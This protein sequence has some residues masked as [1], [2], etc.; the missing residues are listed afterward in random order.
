MNSFFK[1]LFNGEISNC[2]VSK[3]RTMRGMFYQATSFNYDSNNWNKKVE[4][5]E[6]NI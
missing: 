2:N 6:Q 4:I 5:F 3:V 1:K